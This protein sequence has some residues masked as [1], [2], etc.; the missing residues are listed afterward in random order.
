MPAT[1]TE[2][3]YLEPGRNTELSKEEAAAVNARIEAMRKLLKSPNSAA[4]YRIEIRFLRKRSTWKPTLGVMSFWESAGALHGGGSTK[5]Y[6]CRSCRLGD[7][8]GCGAFLPDLV[9]TGTSLI[10]P[11][12][13]TLWKP[14]EVTGELVFNNTMQHWA[15]YIY[16]YYKKLNHNCD[17]CLKHSDDDIRELAVKEQER[18][19]GGELLGRMRSKRIQYVYPLA[20]II[21]DIQGGADIVTRFRAFLTA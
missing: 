3:P 2:V 10:C 16:H 20:N 11:S 7:N 17:I 18:Q 12:C 13:G 15:E 5:L 21:K 19:R 14:E 1:V 4:R 8:R 6:I 9:N